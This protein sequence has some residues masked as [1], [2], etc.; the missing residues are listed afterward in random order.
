A[1]GWSQA[2][3][4]ALC[5][6]E[7]DQLDDEQRIPVRRPVDGTE[8]RVAHDP[9]AALLDQTRDVGRAQASQRE[10]PSIR[11]QRSDPSGDLGQELGLD[12]P[13]RGK[14]ED[15]CV[16]EPLSKELEENR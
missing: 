10:D 12:V 8:D 13:I 7:A 4:L 15:V 14:N 5:G 9:T 1:C 11:D 6:E 3:Q 16:L 2:V